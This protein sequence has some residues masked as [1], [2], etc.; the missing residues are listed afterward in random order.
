MASED[1]LVHRLPMVGYA[2][3][4]GGERTVVPGVRAVGPGVKLFVGDSTAR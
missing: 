3:G 2:V 4:E 1:E